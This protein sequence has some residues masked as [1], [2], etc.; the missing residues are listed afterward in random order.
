[1]NS[2]E[3]QPGDVL[4]SRGTGLLSK[5]IRFFTRR[6]GESRTKVNHVGVIVEGGPLHEARVVE[7][8]WKV[9]RRRLVD[10]YGA[11]GSS[12]V[13]IFR[14]TNL[15]EEEIRTVAAAANSY[16]GR[17]YGVL[18]LFAHLADWVLQGAYVFRRITRMD[19]YPICSWLVA[20]S[21]EKAGKDF[22][23]APGAASPDDIWDFC[24]RETEKYEEVLE[25]GG[26]GGVWGVDP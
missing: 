3:L 24:T 16:V 12:E 1:M 2:L 20:C 22:G 7:A 15:T 13:A 5:A 8:L 18:K 26:L 9:V 23:V 25:L 14:P 11:P 21:F 6:I 19:R 4:V 17:R 10:G